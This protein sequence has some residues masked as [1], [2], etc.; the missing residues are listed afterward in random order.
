M[1]EYMRKVRARQKL[2]RERDEAA[3]AARV[4]LSSLRASST[5]HLSVSDRLARVE[6]ISADIRLLLEEVK[7]KYGVKQ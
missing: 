4:R 2:E 5:A 1:R 7:A 3:N 6:A